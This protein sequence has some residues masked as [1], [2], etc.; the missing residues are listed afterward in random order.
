MKGRFMAWT[1]HEIESQALQLPVHERVQLVERLLTSLD[2][3]TEIERE[4]AEE[5][6]ERL[7][8]YREGRLVAVSGTEV[9]EEVRGRLQR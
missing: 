8:G 2:E 5:V 3:D 9:L 1:I 4:W 6:S 7:E